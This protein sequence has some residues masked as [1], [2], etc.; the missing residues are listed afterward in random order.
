[1]R[2]I[3]FD[4]ITANYV[5]DYA[6]LTRGEDE[7]LIQVTLAA[8]CNTDR[9]MI[10]GYMPG[11]IGVLGHEF[12]GVV[13]DAADRSMVGKRVVGEINLSCFEDDC[14]YCASGRDH[15][16]LDRKTLGIRDKDGCFA[17]YVTLPIRLLHE[18]PDTLSD[19]EAIF[20]EPLAAALRIVEQA[21]FPPRISHLEHEHTQPTAT[22]AGMPMALMGD[23]RL[24]YMIGQVIAA[25]GADLT[26]F[27]LDEDKLALFAPFA[28]TRLVADLVLESD[29]DLDREG[30]KADRKQRVDRQAFE[31]VIDATGSPDSL[32]TSIALTRSEGLLVMKSTYA[33]KARIDMSEVVVRELTI[34]GSRCGPFEPALEMLEDGRITLPEVELFAPSD[35]KKAFASRA[36]KVALDFREGR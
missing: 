30:S 17:D 15:H 35:F 3:H 1:M 6:V 28:Q 22:P 34:Q 11:F 10:R 25:T 18:V 16:C 8:L 33:D 27:G 9:E 21:T 36:F 32:S 14:L 24:A 31:V 20:V 4:G 13:K 23:G 19:E 2:A 12:I 7:A 29:E 5:D 26:V